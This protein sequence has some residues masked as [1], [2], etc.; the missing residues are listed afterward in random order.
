MNCPS[1]GQGM[2]RERLDGQLGAVL[3]VDYCMTCQAF[4]FDQYENLQLTPASTLKLF[5]VIGEAAAAGR[6][7]RW[8][9]GGCPRCGLRLLHTHDIQR[10]TPF[11]Y[12]RCGR[13]HG[14]LISFYDFLREKNFIKPLTAAEAAE[15]RSRISMVHCSNCGAPVDLERRTS[16]SH[17]GSP[18]SLLDLDQ[19]KTLIGQL[20]G[21]G[22]PPPI[23]TEADTPTS[24]S[25]VPPPLPTDAKPPELIGEG[26]K[27]LLSVLRT[28][29]R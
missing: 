27:L 10:N 21:A 28:R 29:V 2:T 4:W 16:C 19:A 13:G 14:R 17:C 8:N 12:W 9:R 1:C 11:E 18:L 25:V 22:L 23:P 15:L 6:P 26:L 5:T 24:S 20:Q 3:Q 7:E